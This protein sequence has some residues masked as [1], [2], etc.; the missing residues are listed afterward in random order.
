MSLHVQKR[1]DTLAADILVREALAR[2]AAELAAVAREGANEGF[3]SVVQSLSQQHRIAAL[4][5]RGQLAALAVDRPHALK[6]D[7]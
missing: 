2:E 7:D 5:M 1:F 6:G 4:Q 3:A